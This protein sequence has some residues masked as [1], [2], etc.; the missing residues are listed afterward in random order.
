MKYATNKGM[1]PNPA[2]RNGVCKSPDDFYQNGH[3]DDRATSARHTLLSDS[4]TAQVEAL[5]RAIRSLQL[6]GQ[7]TN[8]CEVVF[9]EIPGDEHLHVNVTHRYATKVVSGWAGP[10]SI[11]DGFVYSRTFDTPQSEM[12]RHIRAMVL[13]P[14]T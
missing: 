4:W 7:L 8:K 12:M 9:F 14:R 11:P 3:G 1:R 6:D 5:E 10:G 2:G 13:A